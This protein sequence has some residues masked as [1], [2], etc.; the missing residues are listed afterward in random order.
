[1]GTRHLTMVVVDDVYRVAQYGQWDGYPEGQGNT[2]VDFLR[3]EMDKDR[4]IAALRECRFLT[5]KEYK[6]KWTECGA[7]PDDDFV[8]MEVAN[9]FKGKY[10]QLS[11]DTGG[12]ILAL[13]QNG[14]RELKNSLDFAGNSLFCEWAY[15]LDMDNEVLEVYRGFNTE[16]VSEGERFANAER[17]KYNSSKNEDK[18]H[19]IRLWVKIPFAELTEDTIPELN[20]KLEKEYE[21]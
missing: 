14:A 20:A 3:K 19:P 5:E 4:F 17:A 7:D 8:N 10:P 6:D 16:P 21:E 12:G 18:Y 15:L 1:M 13:I 9:R 11:R 2:V